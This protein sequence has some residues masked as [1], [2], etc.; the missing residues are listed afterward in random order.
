[1]T[2][3]TIEIALGGQKWTVEPLP[4]GAQK[5]LQPAYVRLANEITARDG[6]F[7]ESEEMLD[8]MAGLVRDTIVAGGTPLTKDDFEKLPFGIA[9]LVAA[10][11]AIGSALKLTQAAAGEKQPAQA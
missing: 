7:V 10:F 2:D 5:K 1:M 3:D 11:R 6:V 8:Q 9:D 4:W